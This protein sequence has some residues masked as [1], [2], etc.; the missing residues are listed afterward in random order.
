[1]SSFKNKNT[2]NMNLHVNSYGIRI[3]SKD[4]YHSKTI[5]WNLEQDNQVFVSLISSAAIGAASTVIR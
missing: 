1:M 2:K 3:V 5:L 4:A